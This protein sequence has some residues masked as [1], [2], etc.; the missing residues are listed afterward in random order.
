MSN[1]RRPPVHNTYQAGF[2]RSPAW[3]ARRA[4]WFRH[5]PTVCAGCGKTGTPRTVELHHLDYAGVTHTDAGWQAWEK[6]DDLL[7]LCHRCHEQVHWLIDRDYV[8]AH[9]RTRRAATEIALTVLR[10]ELVS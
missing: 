8:L 7:P 3:F 1:R 5:H 2:L 4:R 6:D 10:K 9:L